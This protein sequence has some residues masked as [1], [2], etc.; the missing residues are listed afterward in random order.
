MLAI[1]CTIMLLVA[2]FLLVNKSASKGTKQIGVALASASFLI[3]L[4]SI[5]A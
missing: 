4:V 2:V 3:Y 1:I 5:F